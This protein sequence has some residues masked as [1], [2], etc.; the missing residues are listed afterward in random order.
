MDKPRT[1]RKE[2]NGNHSDATRVSSEFKCEAWQPKSETVTR[3]HTQV[4]VS[5]VISMQSKGG[6]KKRAGGAGLGV[7]CMGRRM[8]RN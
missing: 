1:G 7:G 4:Y 8:V 5:Q 2:N 6:R 3:T